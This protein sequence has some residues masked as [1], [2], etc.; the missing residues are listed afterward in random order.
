M[1]QSLRSMQASVLEITETHEWLLP[2]RV[3]HTRTCHEHKATEGNHGKQRKGSSHCLSLVLSEY[4]SCSEADVCR[5]GLGLNEW[6]SVILSHSRDCEHWGICMWLIGHHDQYIQ[7]WAVQDRNGAVSD[8]TGWRRWELERSNLRSLTFRI[9]IHRRRG[10]A[11]WLAFG[12]P[13]LQGVLML[14]V[15]GLRMVKSVLSIILKIELY[16]HPAYYR[17]I[18]C[19]RPYKPC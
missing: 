16:N 3:K 5:V 7:Q 1:H 6:E 12:F 17:L 19:S 14:W 15:R 11:Q 4:V 13:Q 18:F 10:Q 8:L 9:D 2:V